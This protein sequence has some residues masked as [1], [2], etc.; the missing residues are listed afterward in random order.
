MAQAETG[1]RPT[2][3][4]IA[5]FRSNLR[6]EVDGEA[7]Y[8]MLAA[9]EKN[10]SLK[11]VFL[12][13]AESESRHRALWEEKLREA[14]EAVPRYRPSWRVRS[15]GWLARRFGTGVVAPIVTRMEVAATGMYDNQ[16]E[17]VAANLPAD[18]RSHA[19]LFREIGRSKRG[20]EGLNIAQIE[21]RHRGG[22]GNALRAAVLGV[23]DGLVSNLSLVMGL[24]GADPGR[25]V[26]FVGGLAGLLA[27]A[28]SMALGE[29]ISVRSSA[30]AFERQMAVERAELEM[31]PEEEEEELTLIYQA[32]GFPRDEAKVMAKR[33]LANPETALDTLAREELGMS[34]EEVGN[35][36]IAA[37]TSFVLFT[38]GALIPLVPWLFT[39]G[40]GGVAASGVAAGIALFLA[41]AVT[42]LFTGRGVLFSGSRMLVFGLA[43][44]A[45]TFAIGRAI[46]VSTG[47]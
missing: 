9:A 25:S 8:K 40:V 27:G 14:G 45:I 42:T 15:L 38:V 11:E 3:E 7:L 16:P 17:A 18:E 6:D 32:K 26:V 41:G 46:G 39:G 20:G 24:A 12:R 29:W 33:I 34:A 1:R 30:E 13:L 36:W 10:A 23:N 4:D 5:R 21:G 37:V 35:A 22:T 47:V 31:M 2:R 44:A 43:A 19:R 28:L